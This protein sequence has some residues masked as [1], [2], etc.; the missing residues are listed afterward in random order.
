MYHSIDKD[1]LNIDSSGCV[2]QNVELKKE[3]KKDWIFL[4]R[5]LGRAGREKIKNEEIEKFKSVA[6]KIK[7]IRPLT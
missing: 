1:M 3:L 2:A 4:R 7:H 5:M 6:A